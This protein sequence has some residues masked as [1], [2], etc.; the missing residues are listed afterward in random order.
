MTKTTS[1]HIRIDPVVKKQAEELFALFG[2]TISDAVHMFLSQSLLESGLPFQP[3]QPRYNM[4]TESAIQEARDIAGGKIQAKRFLS[5]D[6][7]LA[8]LALEDEGE[9]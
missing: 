8:D 5:F 4:E 7:Y 1:L 2:I 6:A 9:C 3:K